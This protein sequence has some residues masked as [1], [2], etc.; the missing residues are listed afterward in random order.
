MPLVLLVGVTT[1]GTP[2]QVTVLIDVTSGVGFKVTI[3]VKAAPAQ[4]PEVGITL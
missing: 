2:L 4:V 1:N 3:T